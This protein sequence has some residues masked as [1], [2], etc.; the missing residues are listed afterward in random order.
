[1]TAKTTNSIKT[2]VRSRS[3]DVCEGKLVELFELMPCEPVTAAI[4][5]LSADLFNKTNSCSR[6]RV[7]E[8]LSELARFIGGTGEVTR[9]K[10]V[11]YIHGLYVHNDRDGEHGRKTTYGVPRGKWATFQNIATT[12]ASDEA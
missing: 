9:C 6:G 8:L 5:D 12:V 11:T 7:L 3:V 1:M 4:C 2:K 10:G